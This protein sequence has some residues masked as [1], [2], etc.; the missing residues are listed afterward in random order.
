MS[1]T[2]RTDEVLEDKAVRNE[3]WFGRFDSM[4]TLARQFE[5]ELAT[6]KEQHRQVADK[7]RTVLRHDLHL[8]I[9]AHSELCDMLQILTGE[10]S[11]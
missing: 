3:D 7:I 10:E 5:R 4:W 11:K 6:A 1:D 8:S 2:P 9:P